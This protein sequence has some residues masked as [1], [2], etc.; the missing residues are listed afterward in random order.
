MKGAKTKEDCAHRIDKL[1][2][3]HIA[4]IKYDILKLNK[5]FEELN[6]QIDSKIINKQAIEE[7]SQRIYCDLEELAKNQSKQIKITILHRKWS[8][9]GKV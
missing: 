3:G 9:N 2:D 7:K 1:A 4:K 6:K 8:N 5:K